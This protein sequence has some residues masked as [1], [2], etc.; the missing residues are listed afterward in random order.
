[1]AVN[2]T[3]ALLCIAKNFTCVLLSFFIIIGFFSDTFYTF[4]FAALLFLFNSY[5][6]MCSFR[7][8]FGTVK[9]IF[10]RIWSQ[11]IDAI[12]RSHHHRPLC[13]QFT[14]FT[15]PCIAFIGSTYSKTTARRSTKGMNFFVNRKW[16][17]FLPHLHSY[18][19]TMNTLNKNLIF[20][21]ESVNHR[22][23]S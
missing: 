11:S 2:E 5:F 22:N 19:K 9:W 10:R 3:F 20:L 23:L 14:L 21:Y 15:W 12:F 7:Y 4:S 6:T 17:K 8:F 1:M 16:I 13:S 18:L